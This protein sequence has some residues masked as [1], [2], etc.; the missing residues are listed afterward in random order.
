MK[1]SRLA[2]ASLALA[3]AT[4]VAQGNVNPRDTTTINRSSN[5]LLTNFRF[6]SIGPA[7]M[8]GR[9]D[10]IAVY[11]QDPRL[12]WIG[13]AVGGVFKSTNAGTSFKPVFSSTYGIQFGGTPLDFICSLRRKTPA[14]GRPPV[15]HIV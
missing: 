9:I 3:P 6:R 5:P 15:V 11:E 13:Y 8:G 1:L 14:I 2:L 4:L 7:S 10:D 12:I